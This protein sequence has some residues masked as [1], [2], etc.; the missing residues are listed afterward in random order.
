MPN[1]TTAKFKVDISD[2]KKNIQEAN[3]QIRL[4]N[5]EFKAASAGMDD[6]SK[7]ADGISAKLQQTD[8]VLKAQKTI[9]A[10]YE[11]Q[12]ELISK[13]YG[14]NSKEADEMRIKVENQRAAVAKAEKTAR[15]Y[16]S[17]LDELTSGQTSAKNAFQKL[18]DTIDSQE[19][20]LVQLKSD[21]KAVVLEQGKN[22]DSAKALAKQIDSL[23]SELSA[24]KQSMDGLDKAAGDLDGSLDEAEKGAEKASG[25]FSVF[26]GVLADLVATGIKAAINGLKSLA[27]A[28]KESYVAFDEG[29]DNVIKATG[30]TGEA[31]KE[32]EK[33]YS[34]VAKAVVGD[35]SDIGGALGEINTRFGMTGKELETATEKFMKFSKITGTDAVSAVQLVSRAM[36]DAGIDSSE[37]SDLLDDLASAAQVSGI[38]V[39]K[40][41]E[42]LTKYGAPMRALGMSTKDAIA[43]FSQWEKAGVNTE[44]AFSGM[45]AAIGKWS[46]A[47][48]D[49]RVEFK[50]TLTEIANTPDIA[51]ATTKA[52]EVFGQKAGPDLADAIKGGRFEYSEFL[53]LLES[54]EGTVE[55]TFASTQDASDKVKLAFQSMKV[56]VGE[57]VST[58]LDKY[59]PEIEKAISSITPVIQ[60]VISFIAEKV[61]PVAETAKK[62]FEKI[63]PVVKGI[64]DTFLPVAKKSFDSLLTV[65]RKVFDWIIQNSDIVISALAGIGAAMLAWNLATVVTNVVKMVSALKAMGGMAAFAAAKQ[66]LLNSALLANPI[67]LVVAAVAGLVT[68]FVVLWNKSEKFR[69]FWIGLW[70][71]IKTVAEPIIAALSEWFSETWEKIKDIWKTASDFFRET[72]E[73]IKNSFA[74]EVLVNYFRMAWK[75]IKVIWDV[76]TKYFKTIWDNIKLVFSAVKSV[77]SG[78]FSGAW[79]AVKKIFANSLSFF[80][81][82]WNGIKGIFGNVGEFFGKTFAGARERMQGAFS[83][84]GE[85]IK[86]NFSG[87]LEWFKSNWKNVAL[88]ILNPFAGIFKYLYEHVDGF[89]KIVDTTVK[90]VK[91]FIQPL[92]SWIKTKLIDPVVKFYTAAFNIV[93]ELATGCVRLVKA[94]WS[95]IAEWF[96]SH[97]T[98][99]I[100]AFFGGLWDDITEKAAAAWNLIV[101]VWQVVS[102]W[103]EKHVIK[104]IAKFFADLWNGIKSAAQTAWNF[105]KSVWQAVSGWFNN[106]VVKPVTGFFS[107]MWENLKDGARQAWEGIK[108]VFSHVTDWFRDTFSKAWRAVKDVFSTGGQVFEG[109]KDGIV[110]AFKT[111]VNAIIRGINKVVAIPFNQINDI[112]DSLAGVEIAGIQP[113]SGLV[114]RLPVPQ[115]PEL[116]KGGVLK[117][118]Q[119]GLLEGNG[120]EAV[121][122]LENNKKWIAATA[123]DLRKSLVAEGILGK[124]N[125]TTAPVTNNY[126]F[127]QTNNSPKALS[128]LEIYR[129]SKN[130]LAWKGAT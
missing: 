88:F 34:A 63:A 53:N 81:D 107:G 3:R 43:I 83:G 37:Y 36:G 125:T 17:K 62:A 14:E 10:D 116:E 121:V 130:L 101:T 126:N 68:A 45:K 86:E 112:L 69:N 108:T 24:N 117:R 93:S 82:L 80:G 129:Q 20:E 113:F 42:M 70:E 38:S 40:L 4:A 66:W 15:D 13:E 55:N 95:G 96:S 32:L 92:A 114:H 6:W 109:I 76:A 110:E 33:S 16:R 22:S 124:N 79:D 91:A 123:A 98:E 105:V 9:L 127:N 41:A 85:K 106:T 31:A 27:S 90:K 89:R 97:V 64:F 57:T 23:S 1:E 87:V 25:G 18:S 49:A 100:S 99:P 60:S 30:A 61:P 71:K 11:K 77:F 47:G 119:V 115:I 12:L 2:L 75:N 67:G 48:K 44:I 58:I 26:K 94:V 111:V 52:I 103:F 59:S 56:S 29:R 7:S 84:V 104:P 118:G 102:D 128:R 21:Y 19:K 65:I 46:K 120:S 73:K 39:D 122:P 28:A 8:K 5:A 35:F 51:S 74:F 72:W 78:D 54:S 50:K